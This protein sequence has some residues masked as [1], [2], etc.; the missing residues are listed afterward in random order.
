MNTARVIRAHRRTQ[1]LADI[2]ELTLPPTLDRGQHLYY[3]HNLLVPEEWAGT[4]RWQL[5]NVLAA[6]Y[7]VGSIISDPVTYLGHELIRE[8]TLG[9][10]CPRAERLA[11]RLLCP[12]LHPRMSPGDEAAIGDAIRQATADV[13]RTHPTN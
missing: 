2:D 5:M 9:Q 6:S 1:T 10:H 12:I 7:G 11:A 13:A 8:H 4:G 3:R